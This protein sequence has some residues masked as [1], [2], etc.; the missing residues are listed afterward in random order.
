M[1]VRQLDEQNLHNPKLS[2]TRNRATIEAGYADW[3]S[4]P[5]GVGCIHDLQDSLSIVHWTS[6]KPLCRLCKRR[7]IVRR[8]PQQN[9]W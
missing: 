7:Y 6:A 2:S 5:P 1:P 3:L 9:E 8:Q 4:A